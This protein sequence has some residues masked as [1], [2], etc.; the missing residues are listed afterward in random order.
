MEYSVLG[1]PLMRMVAKEL[2]GAGEVISTSVRPD[3]GAAVIVVRLVVV[4]RL[5]VVAVVCDVDVVV[6]A[7][8]VVVVGFR[9]VAVVDRDAE[10]DLVVLLVVVKA[11][12]EA[13][14]TLR[15]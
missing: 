15:M 8:F 2:R 11:S 3:E 13:G 10:V 4:D 7:G 6:V 5:V 1:L 14:I 9:V 12:P